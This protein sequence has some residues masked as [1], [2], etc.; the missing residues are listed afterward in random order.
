MFFSVQG[1][2]KSQFPNCKQ[3]PISND[4]NSKYFLTVLKFEFGYW[5]LVIV[6]DLFFGIWNFRVFKNIVRGKG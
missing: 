5:L 1:N 3:Y 2:S 6:C 4:Q